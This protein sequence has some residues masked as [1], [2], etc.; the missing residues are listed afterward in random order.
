MGLLPALA[1][2]VVCFGALTHA[3]Y[4]VQARFLK[5]R[6][7]GFWGFGVSD[8]GVLVVCLVFGVLVV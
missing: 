1:L 7:W 6:A 3:M 2:T 4:T 5:I 8:L